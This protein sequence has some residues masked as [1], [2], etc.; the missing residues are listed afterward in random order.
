M[1]R[2]HVAFAPSALEGLKEGFDQV[3]DLLALTLGPRGGTIVSDFR[4]GRT[5]EGIADAATAARRILQV[6][7]QAQ[8]VGAML[9]RNL[10]WRVGQEVGDG[11]ATAAVLAQA[12]LAEGYRSA[13][14]GANPMVMRRGIERGLAAAAACLRQQAQPVRGEDELS[15]LAL[16][17]TGEHKLSLVLGELFDVLGPEAHIIIEE[18]V[19]PYVDREYFEGTRWQARLSSP[20]LVTDAPAQR[21]IV[22]SPLVAIYDGEVSEL[23]EVEPLLNLLAT[24]EGEAEQKSLLLVVKRCLGVAL[25]TLVVNHQAGKLRAAVV[26]FP[27]VADPRREAM[28]DLALSTGAAVLGPDLGRSLHSITQAD[29]GQAARAE[30]DHK[31]LVVVGGKADEAALREHVDAL[32]A[33]LAGAT[34]TEQRQALQERLSRLTGGVATLRIGASSEAGQQELRQKAQKAVKGLAAAGREGTVAGGGVAYLNCVPAVLGLAGT[35]DEAIGL[36]AL[37][38]AL[39]APFRR[40]VRNTGLQPAGTVLYEAQRLGPAFGYDALGDQVVEMRQMGIVDAAGV[41]RRVLEMSVSAAVM[42]LTTAAIVFHRQPT[43]SF[44]P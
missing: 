16:S 43:Q 9:V 19:A 33:R 10:V 1:P 29:L 28:Q 25:G 15:Q 39:E 30:A 27:Q 12:L 3:A 36:Q 8:N 4:A 38:R 42:A 31:T 18:F 6:P 34:Q 22:Q 2:P 32:R 14:A 26:E 13:A 5:A 24:P 23:A 7:G 37:A 21:C 44:E 11:T 20:Y 40:L 17:I 41:C 35:G